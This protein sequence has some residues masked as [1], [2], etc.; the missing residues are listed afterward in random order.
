MN[1]IIYCIIY[2]RVS[3]KRQVLEGN[4][5]RSQEKRCRIFAES[6]GYKVIK[7]FRDEGVSGGIMDRPG[8][9]ELIS[10]LDSR[11]V[12]ESEIVVIVDDIKRWARSVPAHFELKKEIYSRNARLESP[13]YRFEDSP[14][15]QFVET[16]LASAAELERNQNKRQVINRMK[17]RLEMGLWPFHP[18]PGYISKKHKQLGKVLN[19]VE[20]KASIIKE[21]LEGYASNRFLICIYSA[22]PQAL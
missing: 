1:K 2:C 8:M 3:S 15:G 10:F 6:K 16:I 19:P 20:P 5:L 14:E 7:V 4:G 13:S 17:A 18:I 9:Q 12:S 21:A 11:S 22:V